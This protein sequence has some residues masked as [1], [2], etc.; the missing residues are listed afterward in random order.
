MFFP[1][2]LAAILM[3]PANALAFA[4]DGIHWGSGDFR[5]LRNVMMGVS[6]VGAFFILHLDLIPAGRPGVDLGHHGRVG[7]GASGL[8]GAADLARCGP[9]SVCVRG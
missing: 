4:S 2:W 5:Y 8:W 3:Q 1:A 7:G 6:L 9:K